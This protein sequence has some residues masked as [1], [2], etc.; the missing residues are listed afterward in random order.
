MSEKKESKKVKSPEP[1]ILEKKE[2]P[3][4]YNPYSKVSVDRKNVRDF[5][6]E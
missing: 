6:D 4:E 2:F 3:K 5:D 1:P